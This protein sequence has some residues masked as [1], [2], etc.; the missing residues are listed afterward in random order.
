M[1]ECRCY[2]AEQLTAS[3]QQYY[4]AGL[5]TFT[6]SLNSK[7][8][9]LSLIQLA[10]TVRLDCGVVDENIFTVFLGDKPV[11]FRGVKPLDGALDSFGHSTTVA[12]FTTYGDNLINCDA[13]SR[14]YRA[15][16][17]GRRHERPG[18]R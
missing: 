3:L 10:V 4:F 6:S 16:K 8:D 2:R 13:G 14:S 11:A 7:F 1:A 18:G 17:N 12:P 5:E 15:K 9:A